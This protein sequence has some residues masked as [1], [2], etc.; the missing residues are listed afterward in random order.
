[1]KIGE[2]ATKPALASTPC[3]ST[4]GSACFRRRR[5]RPPGIAS[6]SPTW[7]SASSSRASCRR[8]ASRSTE[9]VDAL[10]A[11]DA[12]G[13][14]C[15]SE[16]WRLEAVL[17]RVDTKLAELSALR[18]R[19]VRARCVR[20]RPL[21][22][23]TLR[24]PRR[25]ATACPRRRRSSGSPRRRR[26]SAIRPGWRSPSPSPTLGVPVSATS[27]GSSAATR[28]SSRITCAC[29]SPQAMASVR[30]R[31]AHWVMYE[32]TAGAE[33]LLDVVASRGFPVRLELCSSCRSRPQQLLARA[34]DNS[35]ARAVPRELARSGEAALLALVVLDSRCADR[36]RRL[37]SLGRWRRGRR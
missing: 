14:T 35:R 34:S 30:T 18:G 37:G 2:V 5:E 7:S 19:I 12:G 17:G 1:M 10:A 36:R 6:T 32:L 8:S 4:S 11:H 23:S 31:R 24:R 3:A 33:R 20:R 21:H 26:R 29:S 16:R 22:A 25:Y 9:A 13:A 15:E 28:S 27:R